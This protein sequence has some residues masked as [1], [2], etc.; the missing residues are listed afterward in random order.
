ML[1]LAVALLTAAPTLAQPT[2]PTWQWAKAGGSADFDAL[3]AIA[4]DAT[5]NT[6]VTGVVSDVAQFDAQTL[7]TYGRGDMFVAKYDPAGAVLWVRGGGSSNDDGGYSIAVDAVGNCYVSGSINGEAIFEGTL[8]GEANRT[9]AFV[10]SYTPAGALRWVQVSGGT[11]REVGQGLAV[12]AAGNVYCTGFFEGDALFGAIV[13]TNA[14]PA[15]ITPDGFVVSYNSLGALR[16]ARS[17]G[18]AAA[19]LPAVIGLDA[20]DNYYVDGI[21]DGNA[22]IGAF[23]LTAAGSADGFV[24][25]FNAAGQAVWAQRYGGAGG[26]VE[27]T[28]LAVS[29]GGECYVVGESD[30]PVLDF[31]SISLANPAGAQGGFAGYAVRYDAAG[32]PRW[33]RNVISTDNAGTFGVALRGAEL[34]LAGGFVGTATFDDDAAPVTLTTAAAADLFVARYDTAAGALHTVTRVSGGASADD[35]L[36]SFAIAVDGAGGSHI[37]GYFGGLNGTSTVQFGSQPALTSRGESDVVVAVLSAGP[38]AVPSALAT[39]DFRVYPNP[40]A[41]AARLT[42]QGLPATAP[43]RLTLLDALGRIVEAA[44]VAP[45]ATG[46][47]A[48]ML[49]AVPAGLYSLRAEQ[50]GTARVRRVVVE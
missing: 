21:F 42:V 2:A 27:A 49:P 41:P 17:F 40:A 36:I 22:R 50:N 16:W 1:T 20:A 19:E 25:R 4:V 48:W 28:G 44:T 33:G 5:G 18:G 46:S 10:V 12:D 29:P 31:G 8:V 6:Y 23:L 39:A 15:G 43:V 9:S 30:A 45:D 24:A 13:L 47:A 14:D 35:L 7:P 26:N 34:H 11:A 37:G 32:T 3:T 38:L